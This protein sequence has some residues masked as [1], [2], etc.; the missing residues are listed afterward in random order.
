MHYKKLMTEHCDMLFF[1]SLLLFVSDKRIMTYIPF[2]SFLHFTFS[3]SDFRM[4]KKFYIFLLRDSRI[5]MCCFDLLKNSQCYAF[6]LLWCWISPSSSHILAIFVL[7]PSPITFNC[8]V[9][10]HE[11][12]D[13]LFGISLSLY[14]QVANIRL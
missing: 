4:T 1:S 12:D 2:S 9:I 14:D 5:A 6:C 8:M 10:S 7:S 13:I 11:K 3:N